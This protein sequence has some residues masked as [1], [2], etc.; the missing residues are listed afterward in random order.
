MRLLEKIVVLDNEVQAQ[1]L[2]KSLDDLGIPH[3]MRSYHDSA[4]DG[5]Y[6]VSRGWGHVEAPR[7]C[8]AE[9]LA[10]LKELDQF[11]GP[12][13]FATDDQSGSGR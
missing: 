1:M 8:K 11:A 13:G 9:I 7:E 6:Q 12:E 5:L 2:D 3:V 4:Y 10:I